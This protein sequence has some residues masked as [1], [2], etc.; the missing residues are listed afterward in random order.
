MT[1]A[2]LAAATAN[3]PMG[4]FKFTGLGAG[5]LSTDSATY[6]QL[7]AAIDSYCGTSTGSANNQNAPAPNFSSVNGQKLGVI[8]GVTNTSSLAFNTLT[9]YKGTATGPGV[10]TGGEWVIGNLYLLEYSSALNTTGGLMLLGPV[11]LPPFGSG[12]IAALANSVNTTGGLATYQA[13]HVPIVTIYASGTGTY[14]T[15]AGA[16]YVTVEMVGGGSGGGGGGGGGTASTAGG[17]T[18]FGG[19]T[20]NGGI[21]ANAASGTSFPAIAS[22]SGGDINIPGSLGGSGGTFASGSGG[23]AAYSGG[24]GASFYGGGAPQG[25]FIVGGST[26]N[27]P[28]ATVPGAGGG[29]GSISVDTEPMGWGGNSGAY[30]SKAFLAPSATYSYAVGAGGAGG[31][32]GTDGGNGSAGATGLI[33]VIAYFQ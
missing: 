15:P 16:L 29:G 24:G 5:T 20:A 14:T 30:L 19:L 26:V 6:G 8:A 32:A 2:G 3:I 18:T 7:L 33:K 17:A 12:V 31:T 25:Y 9:V 27:P 13:A 1:R 28:I 10:L 4:G 21:A 23:I 22:A 11:L